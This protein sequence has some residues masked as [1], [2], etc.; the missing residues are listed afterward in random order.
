MMRQDENDYDVVIAGAGPAGS[1]LA[2]RLALSGRR[3]ML[4]EQKKFPREKLCGEF[5]SPECIAHLSDLGVSPEL[6]T[7]RGS[8]IERT[9]FYTRS[10]RNVTIPSSW[11]NADGQAAV[12]LSRAELDLALLNRAKELGVDVRE[13]TTISGLITDDGIV[14]GVE[15]KQAGESPGAISSTLTVDATG[16]GRVLQRFVR[17]EKR[18]QASHVAFKTHLQNAAIS[19]GT[20]EIYSYAGGY[21]GCNFVEDSLANICFIVAAADARKMGSDPERVFREILMTNSRAKAALEKST[22]VKPWLAVPIDRYG[23]GDLVPADGLL[24]VGDAA[25]FIDPF[26][27]SGILLALESAEIA[28]HAI[29]TYFY[30]EEAF[31]RLNAHYV[32]QYSQKI[33]S[34]LR[35]SSIVRKFAYSPILASGLVTAL[36]I[37]PNITRRVAR[38][39]RS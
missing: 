14:K 32:N 13:E 35:L 15:I 38:A 19:P 4:V 18:E 2:I 21:G 37:S 39:T 27:G 10:G 36:N 1:S 7:V 11:F 34:R 22:P 28:A 16:R 31:E 24:S 5:V 33:N 9:V 23:R 20:C 8:T 26:T 17:N 6:T 3:V 25:G 12:G 29:A 30:Q